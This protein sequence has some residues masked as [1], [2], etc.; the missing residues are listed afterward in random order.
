MSPAELQLNVSKLCCVKCKKYLSNPPVYVEISGDTVCEECYKVTGLAPYFRN[1][2]YEDLLKEAFFPCVYAANGCSTRVQFSKTNIHES[3]CVFKHN[4]CPVELC[5]WSGRMMML[6][7]HFLSSIH[8][9]KTLEK[10]KFEFTKD[11]EVFKLFKTKKR[12]FVMWTSGKSDKIRTELIN[13]DMGD[14]VKYVFSLY[15][16]NAKD[17]V[18]LRKEGR[19]RLFN[20][21]MREVVE[22]DK[23]V[24]CEL[25]GDT[26]MLECY[27]VL[28]A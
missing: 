18:E 4:R 13:L 15:N 2:I 11:S 10:P 16:P 28:I 6:H 14:S 23:K 3:V 22:F 7:E 19:T 8:G 21:T 27:F 25:L 12:S 20:G 9:A 5:C 24:L 1:H 17:K 26:E